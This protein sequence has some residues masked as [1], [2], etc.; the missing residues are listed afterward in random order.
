MAGGVLMW[1]LMG[2]SAAMGGCDLVPKLERPQAGEPPGTVQATPGEDK[3]TVE[4]AAAP[5]EPDPPPP[6]L[7]LEAGDPRR[8]P[9]VRPTPR[10]PEA[11]PISPPGDDDLIQPAQAGRPGDASAL[12]VDFIVKIKDAELRTRVLDIFR[13]DREGA[14]AA[15]RDWALTHDLEGFDLVGATYSGEIIIHIGEDAPEAVRERAARTPARSMA[16][17]I[18]ARPNVVYCDPDYTARPGKAD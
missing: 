1:L 3:E 16:E 15:F 5:A 12:D 14:R 4:P 13:K 17:D 11:A 8:F 9:G 6:D 7:E 2:S 18:A 10:P